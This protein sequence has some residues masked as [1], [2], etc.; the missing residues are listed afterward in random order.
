MH[1]F[2]KI[3]I[4]GL[5]TW[6][7][8]GIGLYLTLRYGAGLVLAQAPVIS[9]IPQPDAPIR[10]SLGK[11][12]SDNPSAPAFEYS[13]VNVS[14]KPIR[15]HALRIDDGMR[16]SLLSILT[17]P[18]QSGQTQ[19]GTYGDKTFSPPPK[20]IEMSV[21]FV[22]FVDGTTWG[23]DTTNAA[24][25]VAGHYAGRRAERDRLL[26]LLE[27]GGTQAV[28]SAIEADDVQ[29][30]P[31]SGRSERWE[32]NYRLGAKY[33]RLGLRRTYKNEGL[34]AMDTSLRKELN[35]K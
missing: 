34:A 10:I 8:F 31:Q 30:I 27:E 25:R 2:R 17:F 29:I 19:P 13:I 21:D 6:L 14:D 26:K 9:I 32:D 12:V 5:A 15:A 28:I 20:G 16:G 3:A 33:Y 1:H 18:L 7:I 22:E 11:V 23:P 35:Q 24:E 4:A